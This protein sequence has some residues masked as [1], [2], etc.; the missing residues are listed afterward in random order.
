MVIQSSL[1]VPLRLTTK[2]NF[3]IENGVLTYAQGSIYL[4]EM[5]F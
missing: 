1:L 4:T 5:L 3:N 2:L